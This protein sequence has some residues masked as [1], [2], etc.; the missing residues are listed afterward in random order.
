M[1]QD[2]PERLVV[3]G[4]TFE[5]THR[6][7]GRHDLTWLSGPN[8]GYGFTSQTSTRDPLT[9]E[10]LEQQVRD[11]LAEIDPATGYLSEPAAP[12]SYRTSEPGSG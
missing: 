1:G 6:G 11:F 2:P 5:L 7:E 4:Q 12:G 3:D 9:R 10:Q 8:P